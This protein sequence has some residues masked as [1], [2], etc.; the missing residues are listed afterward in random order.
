MSS[1]ICR[2]HDHPNF[3]TVIPTC[4]VDSALRAL[5]KQQQKQQQQQ[6]QSSSCTELLKDPLLVEATAVCLGP[7]DLAEGESMDD[8]EVQ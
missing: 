8:F 5:N 6:Q 2:S 3:E 4:T 7:A 1:S